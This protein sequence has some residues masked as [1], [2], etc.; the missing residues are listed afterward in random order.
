VSL[1]TYTQG[2]KTGK[3]NRKESMDQIHLDGFWIK[4]YGLRISFTAEFL[5]IY[6]MLCA[7]E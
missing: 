4:H 6:K 3:R 5:R 2:K 1:K 7:L